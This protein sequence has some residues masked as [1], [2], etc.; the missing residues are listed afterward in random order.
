MANGREEAES[1]MT[2][3]FLTGVPN[4]RLGIVKG[5]TI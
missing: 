4:E 1:Q 2:L 3:K 5:N